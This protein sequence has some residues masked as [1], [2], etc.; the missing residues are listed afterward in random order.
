MAKRGC[1]LEAIEKIVG[2]DPRVQKI[3]EDLALNEEGAVGQEFIAALERAGIISTKPADATEIA[4]VFFG[5]KITGSGRPG[6]A[7]SFTREALMAQEDLI[8]LAQ[9]PEAE[10]NFAALIKK[11]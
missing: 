6:H 8:Y 11:L 10:V 4:G 5:V 2:P 9:H 3:F 7:M 1:A